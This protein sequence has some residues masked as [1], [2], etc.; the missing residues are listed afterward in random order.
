MTRAALT[1]PALRAPLAAS[2]AALGAVFGAVLGASPA[3]GQ[4]VGSPAITWPAEAY[5]PRPATGDLILPLPCGGAIAFRRVDTPLPPS[6]LADRQASLGHADP[7]TDHQEFLRQAFLAGPFRDEG[8]ASSQH[9]FLAKHEVTADQFAAVMADACPVPLPSPQGRLP[10]TNVTWLE[11]AAFTQRA[12]A[13][14]HKNARAALPASDGAAAFLRLPTEEE[15]EFAARGGTAVSEADFAGRL[16]PMEGGLERQAWFQGPRSA[17]GR[18]RPVGQ[19]TPNPLGLHDM[20]GN[21][22]E[23]ALEPFRLNRVGR[24]HGLAGGQVARGG[25]FRT[26]ADDL[27]SSWR[28]EFAPINPTTSEPMRS[29][30]IGFRPALG[31]VAI[32]DEAATEALR[33]SFA[34]EA[35]TRDALAEDPARLLQALRNDLPEGAVRAGLARVEGSLLAERRAR[36]DGESLAIRAQM[37]AAAHMARQIMAAFARQALNADQ[38]ER[39]EVIG[40]NLGVAAGEQERLARAAPSGPLQQSLRRQAEDLGTIRGQADP[41]AEALRATAAATAQIVRDLGDGYIRVV[42]ALGG[43]F[44]AARLDEE[45]AVLAREAA[46]RAQPP[47]LPEAQALALRHIRVAAAGHAPE[48]EAAVRDLREEAQRLMRPPAP[49]APPRR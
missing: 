26:P 27:R 37:E 11:A 28:I 5:N 1:I 22:A 9:Y 12:S 39:L 23:W 32:P 29:D 35:R 31:R 45:A 48:R 18:A 44:P 4:P 40:R 36:A 20:F 19:L 43:G 13:W 14:L 10:R 16:P 47:W 41:A 46:G 17:A 38:A 21:V 25:G 7:A 42:R 33:R 24:P 49:A 30:A 6:P 34:E 8:R 3:A 2:A 15:W